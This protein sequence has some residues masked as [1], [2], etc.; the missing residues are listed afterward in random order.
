MEPRLADAMAYAEEARADL[1]A[2]LELLPSELREARPTEEGW[3]AAEILEHLARVEKGIAKLVALKVAEL[4]GAGH[5]D[6]GA[7]DKPP[8]DPSRFAIVVEATAKLDAPDRTRPAGELSAG[9]AARALG[10]TRA[11]LRAELAKGDG[12]ALA[13]AHHPHPFLGPLD[14]HEW[15]FFVGAHERRHAA[16]LRALAQHFASAT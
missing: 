3:S 4:A 6:D 15:V 9:A 7:G 14:L 1:L 13:T 2:T 10:E 5:G 12:L 16:Q 8:I 11:M